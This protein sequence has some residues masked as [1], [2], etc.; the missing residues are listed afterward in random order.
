MEVVGSE[1][2]LK[3]IVQNDQGSLETPRMILGQWSYS[4]FSNKGKRPKTTG[5]LSHTPRS[6][7]RLFFS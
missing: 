5:E 1:E 3:F 6:R 4:Q 2:L 7:R